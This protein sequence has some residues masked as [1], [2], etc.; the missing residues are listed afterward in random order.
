MGMYVSLKT[1]MDL[2]VRTMGGFFLYTKI[3]IRFY[4]IGENLDHLRKLASQ[5]ISSARSNKVLGVQ[6]VLFLSGLLS[7]ILSVFHSSKTCPTSSVHALP[8]HLNSLKYKK[9]IIKRNP[10]LLNTPSQLHVSDPLM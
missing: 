4:K 3:N 9:I 2:K 1:G 6:M 8:R 10:L 5:E 7:K